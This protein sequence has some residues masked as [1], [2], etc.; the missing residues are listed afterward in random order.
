MD[1]FE[2]RH[3]S[4]KQVV[5]LVLFMYALIAIF[6]LFL[7]PKADAGETDEQ[8]L[9]LDGLLGRLEYT[10][11]GFF[12]PVEDMVMESELAGIQSQLDN[13]A[14]SA[15]ILDR[16]TGFAVW[17]SARVRVKPPLMGDVDTSV[18]QVVS[19]ADYRYVIQNFW[20]KKEGGTRADFQMVVALPVD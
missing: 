12:I 5:W 20:L 4:I 14:G 2:S 3:S 9:L 15:W 6:L 1:S 17:G 11:S 13:E 8:A 7:P 10:E 18:L 19:D 16:Q